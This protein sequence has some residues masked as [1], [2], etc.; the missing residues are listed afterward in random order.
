MQNTSFISKHVISG[1]YFFLNLTPPAGARGVVV[2]GGLENCAPD[3]HIIRSSF[4]YHSLEYVV[5]GEGELA[6]NEKKYPLHAG[7]MFGYSPTTR[8]AI[9]TDPKKLLVKY[10]VDFVGPRFT[11]LL[12][13]HPLAQHKPY[14]FSNH[15]GHL[16]ETLHRNGRD[17]SPQIHKICAC[18]LEL[19]IL[20]TA[21]A[22]L[23]MK[24]AESP[25]HQSFQQIRA[26]IEQEF[27]SFSKLSDIASYCHVD[28]SYACR[29]FKRYS[30]ESPYEMLVRLKM[31][32]AA[33]LLNNGHTLIKDVA[34]TVGFQDPYHFSRSFKAEYGVSPKAFIHSDYR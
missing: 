30:K 29:L 24:D 2:C 3:Y 19:L 1:E 17:K 23:L 11:Q 26:A 33:D 6:I 15:V 9:T 31:R 13:T 10:F 20:Q 8:H 16:F 22:A 12:E 27:L 14:Y 7:A 18:L 5:K 32:H 4:K 28:A 34:A 25:A 21:D